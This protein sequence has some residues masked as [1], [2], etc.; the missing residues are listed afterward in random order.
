MPCVSE[1]SQNLISARGWL[2]SASRYLVWRACCKE[3]IFICIFLPPLFVVFYRPRELH[4]RG[5]L[6]R[7]HPH[8][9]ARH[10]LRRE[11]TNAFHVRA[12]HVVSYLFRASELV[13]GVLDRAPQPC[14]HRCMTPGPNPPNVS[15]SSADTLMPFAC[16]R[17]Y[18]PFL[19]A[20]RPCLPRE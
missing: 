10:A 15:K 16:A 19:S 9:H 12:D 8:Q 5:D 2:P 18:S 20:T 17:A 13:A 4:R 7:H 3:F 11:R 1:I 14:M 6:P